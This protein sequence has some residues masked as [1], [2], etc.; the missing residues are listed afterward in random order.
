M[1]LGEWCLV[2]A[3]V[4]KVGPGGVG[5]MLGAS[6]GVS[7]QQNAAWKTPT[8]LSSAVGN[9]LLF[10]SSIIFHDN[11]H[12]HDTLYLLL[13]SCDVYQQHIHAS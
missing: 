8:K 7:N 13:T 5:V 2:V 12:D 3:G 6:E 11:F 4:V 9:Y 1:V 10:I